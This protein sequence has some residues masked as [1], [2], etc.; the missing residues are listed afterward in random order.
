MT[1]DNISDAAK[2]IN[3]IKSTSPQGRIVNRIRSKQSQ[4]LAR[5][6]EIRSRAARIIRRQRI[7]QI[8]SD[9]RKV[10][11][12]KIGWTYI[13]NAIKMRLKTR[14]A[15][16]ASLFR[17]DALNLFYD[18]QD[19]NALIYNLDLLGNKRNYE[20]NKQEDEQREL[21]RTKA[22]VIDW[23]QNEITR[24]GIED[25]HSEYIVSNGNDTR[26]TIQN[27]EQTT[28]NNEQPKAKEQTD[29]MSQFH[30]VKEDRLTLLESSQPS[31]ISEKSDISDT[32][33]ISTNSKLVQFL[34]TEFYFQ[35]S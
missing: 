1:L 31:N 7:L 5:W 25:K 4:K 19:N 3:N 21:T 12:G 14:R 17:E 22:K 32:S 35:I 16:S 26:L 23:L 33:D 10:S 11:Y 15:E 28:L 34:C 9:W 27:K 13:C 29:I 2:T 24:R 8:N 20:T 30:F 6:E 18:Q